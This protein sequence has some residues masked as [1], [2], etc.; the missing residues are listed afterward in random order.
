MK[1]WSSQFKQKKGIWPILERPS[2]LSGE[3]DQDHDQRTE[4]KID[5]FKINKKQGYSLDQE[6]GNDVQSKEISM[7]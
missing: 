4:I 1:K 6:G 3:K 7:L 5:D 2:T